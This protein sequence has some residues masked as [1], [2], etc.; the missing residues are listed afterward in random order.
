MHGHSSW[1]TFGL[2]VVRG[3]KASESALLVKS[4]YGSVKEWHDMGQLCGP[5]CKQAPEVGS[6]LDLLL[7]LTNLL[8]NEVEQISFFS[9]ANT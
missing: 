4:D 3:P 7:P 2:H 5:W 8:I 6:K 9:D 1:S